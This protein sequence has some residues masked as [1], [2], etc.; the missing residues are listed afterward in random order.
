MELVHKEGSEL[1]DGVEMSM[2]LSKIMVKHFGEHL[3]SILRYPPLQKF[4]IWIHLYSHILEDMR[5]VSFADFFVLDTHGF[6]MQKKSEIYQSFENLKVLKTGGVKME[7]LVLD[8]NCIREYDEVAKRKEKISLMYEFG[9]AGLS[10][11][12]FPQDYPYQ[13]KK[14]MINQA[15]HHPFE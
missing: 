14:D 9:C 7:K 5:L 3:G 15:Y 6:A 1:F 11:K 2:T 8:L 10:Y 4:E 13:S 12:Y